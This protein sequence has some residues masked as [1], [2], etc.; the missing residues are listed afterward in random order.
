MGRFYSNVV[1][2]TLGENWNSKYKYNKYYKS[3]GGE[4]K[5]MKKEMINGQEYR[6]VTLRNRS[7]LVSKDGD[8]INP[9]RR[10]QQAKVYENPDGYLCSGGGVPVHLYVAHGWVDGYKEGLEV[11]HKDF[12][13]H[14]NNASNLE[15]VTHQEN[16]NYSVNNNSK[17]WN[18]SKQG[19]NNGRATFTEKQVLE[20]RNKYD[21]GW[22]IADIVR[23]DYP[24]LSHVKDYKNIHS[25]YSNICHRKTWKNI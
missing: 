19:I 17:I 22:S 4:S 24:E 7:K 18:A 23:Y 10:N 16:I 12:D 11:N 5:I 8:L 15:W 20:I 6:L 13:R 14:N 1:Q 21:N 3:K 2:K 9:F 25:T